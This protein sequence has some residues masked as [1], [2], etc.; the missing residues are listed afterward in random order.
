MVGVGQ[1][2]NVGFGC[3]PLD[4]LCSR[5]AHNHLTRLILVFAIGVYVF[6]LGLIG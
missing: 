2:E 4:L 5:P 3:N 6:A 1:V